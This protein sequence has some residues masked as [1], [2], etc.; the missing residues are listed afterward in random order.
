MRN[1]DT[2]PVRGKK[3]ISSRSTFKLMTIRIG[4]KSLIERKPSSCSS[5]LFSFPSPRYSTRWAGRCD[6]ISKK[7]VGEC[8]VLL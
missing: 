5:S 8:F 2:F 6:S 1:L 4:G 3:L 7:L